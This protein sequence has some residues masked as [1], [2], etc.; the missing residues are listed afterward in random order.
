MR[1][2]RCILVSAVLAMAPLGAN[3]A[4]GAGRAGDRNPPRPVTRSSTFDHAGNRR[5]MALLGEFTPAETN[6]A[7]I[8]GYHRFSSR[9]REAL[10]NGGADRE[11]NDH[12]F[13]IDAA[14]LGLRLVP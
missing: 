9:A 1:E 8:A 13:S 4:I 12:H 5:E 3:G 14:E 10:L 7:M 11:A 6:V 2:C